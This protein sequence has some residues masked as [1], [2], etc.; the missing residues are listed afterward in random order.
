MNTETGLRRPPLS[1]N[2]SSRK[3]GAPQTQPAIQHMFSAL[4][5]SRSRAAR[6]PA[7]CHA[8]LR[9]G[10]QNIK[11]FFRTPSLAPKKGYPQ[12]RRPWRFASRLKSGF[13]RRAHSQGVVMNSHI[14]ALR[15]HNDRILD[16]APGSAAKRW[17]LK[18][19][20][21]KPVISKK[22]SDCEILRRCQHR[23]G[24]TSARPDLGLR[25]LDF[26]LSFFP[27]SEH[28]TTDSELQRH[29]LP[30]PNSELQT[31]NCCD[32]DSDS[33]PDFFNFGL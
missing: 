10:I 6:P 33:D 5:E 19:K 15:Q 20:T 3:S 23:C 17:G 22:R 1:P 2:K 31:H 29:P 25:T 12:E 13:P 32:T 8:G 11:V 27:N 26:D 9:S 7:A 21:R 16:N 28:R 18:P 4:Q 14:R 24:G 30:T